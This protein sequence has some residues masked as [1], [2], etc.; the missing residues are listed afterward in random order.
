MTKRK[1]LQCVI[2][3]ATSSFWCCHITLLANDSVC[4]RARHYSEH[5][6]SRIPEFFRGKEYSGDQLI[7][8]SSSTREG[9]YFTIPLGKKN[10]SLRNAKSVELQ[11]IDSTNPQPRVLDYSIFEVLPQKKI[12]LVGVTGQDWNQSTM[13]LVAWKVIIFGA[14]QKQIFSSQSTLWAHQE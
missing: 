2:L 3:L 4:I 9:L 11:I 7:V 8:R 14:A 13:D 12:L 5:A 10:C 1:W 6:F